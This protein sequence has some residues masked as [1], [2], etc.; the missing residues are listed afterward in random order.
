MHTHLYNIYI[1]I[2]IY[3][4][5]KKLKQGRKKLKPSIFSLLCLVVLT[6]LPL[7]NLI[8]SKATKHLALLVFKF[9]KIGSQL[10]KHIVLIVKLCK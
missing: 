8:L 2:Y 10:C 1:Y 5:H 6:I 3:K 7:V 9:K 4:L